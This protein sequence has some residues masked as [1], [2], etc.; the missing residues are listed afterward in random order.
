MLATMGSSTSLPRRRLACPACQEYVL[1]HDAGLHGSGVCRP[2]PTTPAVPHTPP[3]IAEPGQG[4]SPVRGVYGV[5]W[6]PSRVA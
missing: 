1:C 5:P 2:V 6:T 4:V 3:E